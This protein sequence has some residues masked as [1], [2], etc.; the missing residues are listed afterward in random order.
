[1]CKHS[2]IE[3]E[4]LVTDAAP[5]TP[6]DAARMARRRAIM[7]AQSRLFDEAAVPS[8]PTPAPVIESRAAA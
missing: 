4:S 8:S 1:M 6:E 5:A 2:R 7:E 3:V